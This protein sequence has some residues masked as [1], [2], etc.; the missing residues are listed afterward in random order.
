MIPELVILD[1]NGIVAARNLGIEEQG[2]SQ[3]QSARHTL[4]LLG[5]NTA[6][7]V[8]VDSTTSQAQSQEGVLPA[9]RLCRTGAYQSSVRRCTGCDS[10]RA[11]K[12][13][14]GG[15]EHYV[16]KVWESIELTE[17]SSKKGLRG[18]ESRHRGMEKLESDVDFGLRLFCPRQPVTLQ[19][20]SR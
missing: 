19:L 11:G 5:E 18:G 7:V 8:V 2:Q 15:T 1:G 10:G 3:L 16:R 14:S 17:S 9:S 12:R 6:R 13:S 20:K 4:R